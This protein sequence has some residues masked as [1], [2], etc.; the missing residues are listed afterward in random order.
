MDRK[1]LLLI[2]LSVLVFFANIGGTSI[3]ILD[4]AKNAGCAMEMFQKNEWVVPTFNNALRFDKPPLHY[5]FMKIGYGVFGISPF[6]ARF[7]S[8][9]M[10]VLLVV[11]MYYFG[12]RNLKQEAA[13]YSCLI[14]I[15]SLQVAFQFHLAVPD[16]Y[17][18]F[19]CTVGL[20][21][22]YEAVKGSGERFIYGCYVS[23]SLAVLA[24]GPV[25]IVLPGMIGLLF[26][27]TQKKITWQQLLDIKLIHGIAIAI[28]IIVPWYALVHIETG[29]VW[30]ERFIWK[31]NVGRFTNTMEGHGGFPLAS[32]LII[33]AALLP[34][35]LFFPPM[36]RRVWSLRKKKPFLL[37]CLI[38]V[39]V[40]GSFFAIS[41]TILP[42]Y[43][44]PALPFFAF[45]LGYYFEKVTSKSKAKKIWTAALVNVVVASAIPVV[46]Y[47]ALK[48]DVSLRSL[49]NV[50]WWFVILPISA[51]V[52]LFFV[53]KGKLKE[54]LYS[55][56]AGSIS[57]LLVF[58][59]LI[60]PQL[61]KQNPVSQSVKL[62]PSNVRIGYYR[63][64]N[65]AFVFALQQ[66]LHPIQIDSVKSA[67]KFIVVTQKEYLNDFDSMKL[68][69]LFEGKDLFENPVTVVFT[70]TE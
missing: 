67:G 38:T 10:G 45:M 8:A 11:A 40:V 6:A 34:Y 23:L 12:K 14:M 31:H 59:Y 37:Y 48:H 53:F 64:F 30:T 46:A 1:L 7:F 21:C 19:F 32:F 3:Y 28:V 4:E 69:T 13:F 36:L 29:G 54:A 24:K 25:A 5:F 22:F 58:F 60:Y 26:L 68:N 33:I 51:C 20:L 66:P 17:L 9:V 18:I 50:S 56:A 55:Y 65:P 42:S 2:A 27:A 52:G 16:P 47:F 15:S 62:I 63:D 43:I 44:G 57:L 35:S 41:R 70:T 61:D 39:L 49:A